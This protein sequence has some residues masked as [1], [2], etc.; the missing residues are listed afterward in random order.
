MIV[1]VLAAA[2]TARRSVLA[3]TDN[4]MPLAF[5][6]GEFGCHGVNNAEGRAHV[7]DAL[8]EIHAHA[9]GV[10]FYEGEGGLFFRGDDCDKC[11]V[12][13]YGSVNNDVHIGRC[14]RNKAAII[15]EVL[16]KL[17]FQHEQFHPDAGIYVTINESLL[18]DDW[19]AQW[20]GV[21]PIVYKSKFDICSVMMYEPESIYW[22]E[23]AVT[24]TAK[25]EAEA[26]KCGDEILS[27]GDIDTLNHVYPHTHHRPWGEE[28][29]AV[30]MAL[31]FMALVVAVI[32]SVW[33]P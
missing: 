10:V 1:F 26:S 16:H 31:V 13:G 5:S 7:I 24:Y 22:P 15:H 14:A 27:K 3:A 9:R 18:P 33:W 17:G 25:G 11:N 30:T 4:H 2:V 28:V 21:D 32:A 20:V 19:K 8:N 29:L 12:Y 6:F 23:S